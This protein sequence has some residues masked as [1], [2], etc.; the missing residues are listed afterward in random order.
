MINGGFRLASLNPANSRFSF[1]CFN[2]L[3][4]KDAQ[5]LGTTGSRAPAAAS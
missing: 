3:F 4:S 5:T 1:V 2:I